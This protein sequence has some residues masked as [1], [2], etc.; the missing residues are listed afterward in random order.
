MTKYLFRVDDISE[1]MRFDR[2]KKLRKIFIKY[3]IKPVL[4]VIP[5]NE[6][7]KIMFEHKKR[8]YLVEELKYLEKKGWII[9]QH[10]HTHELIGNGGLLNINNFGEFGGLSFKEQAKKISEGKKI[11][12]KEGFSPKIFI[13][14]A[15]SFD[16]STLKI[17]K[18][19]G[20]TLINDGIGLYPFQRD[21]FLFLPQIT[22]QVRTFP[23]GMITI[24]LHPHE[25]KDKDLLKIEKFIKKNRKNIT[26]I[27][28][29]IINFKKKSAFVKQ[30]YNTIN[31][32][33]K[34][35]WFFVFKG[36]KKLLRK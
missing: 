22:W 34:L 12:E 23:L 17:L 24:G 32:I 2:F 27:N 21:G 30:L 31:I 18:K 25:L 19:H 8:K 26:D 9:A 13:A 10:G 14:P 7:K 11:L 33:F 36:Y 6:H 4:A 20:M 15:H 35:C 3:N 28:K 5:K 1:F 16:K 29:V